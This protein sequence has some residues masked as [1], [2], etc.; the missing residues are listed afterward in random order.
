[1]RL[2]CCMNKAVFLDRD[3]VINIDYG[4]VYKPSQLVFT[5]NVFQAL[6]IIKKNDFIIIII[7]NQSGV[8][9]GFFNLADVH[10]FHKHINLK[11]N[12]RLPLNIITKYYICP[13][14]PDYDQKCSCR[15]P[16]PGMLLDAMKEFDIDMNQSIMVGDKE[17]DMLCGRNA[18]ISNL[19]GINNT[20][21]KYSHATYKNLYEWAVT[22]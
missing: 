22:L 5:E 8:A 21:L 15:K 3:G 2:G 19:I 18:K 14:H 12:E 13:H 17:S 1:M 16:N 10:K 11:L 9:R 6:D 4:Y 20:H 7:T